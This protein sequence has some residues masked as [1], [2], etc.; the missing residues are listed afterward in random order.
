MA[1]LEN[2]RVKLAKRDRKEANGLLDVLT[3]TCICSVETKGT[4]SSATRQAWWVAGEHTEWVNST[5][6]SPSPSRLAVKAYN[7]SKW[8]LN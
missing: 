6:R 3:P 1:E 2:E 5:S 4:R 8:F 7:G